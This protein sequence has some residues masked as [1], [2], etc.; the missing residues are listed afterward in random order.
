MAEGKNKIIF[1]KDWGNVFKKLTDEEAGRLIKHFCHYVDD[2]DPE[3]P[4]RITEL[5]FEPIKA[6]LKRD[7]KKWEVKS[8]VNKM[9]GAKGGRPKLTEITQT[10]NKKPNGLNDNPK[11]GVSDSV[12]VI[13]SDS[14]T[15]KVNEIVIKEK[16]V[17]LSSLDFQSKEIIKNEFNRIAFSF[18]KLFKEN[19][20]TATT[21]NLDR[22]T[23]EDWAKDVRLMIDND[24]RTLEEIQSVF[25]FL[26]VSEFWKSNIQ[27]IKK[28]REQFEKLYLQ[29]KQSNDYGK[30]QPRNISQERI[31]ALK[32]W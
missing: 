6:T 4:D 29:S 28:L 25:K 26:K 18:W 12:S 2:E 32:K 1:Y 17:L 24:G 30:K 15:D 8:N 3:S 5:L 14:V 7:L 21:K 20:K 23:L 9:N 16:N 22:A 11:K 19:S 13:V 10:V 31:D 27:S